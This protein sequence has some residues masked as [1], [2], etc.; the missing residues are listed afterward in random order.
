MKI[1]FFT[2]CMISVVPGV[3]AALKDGFDEATALKQ[4]DI[5]EIDQ[6]LPKP[7]VSIKKS[8]PTAKDSPAPD[9]TPLQE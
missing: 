7:N 6:Y 5:K 1:L 2:L 3:Q 4:E 9:V 8:T